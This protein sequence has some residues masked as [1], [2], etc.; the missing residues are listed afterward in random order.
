MFPITDGHSIKITDTD[1]PV[2]IQNCI[3]SD[4]LF[5]GHKSQDT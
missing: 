4:P 1:K 3:G 5:I 2:A